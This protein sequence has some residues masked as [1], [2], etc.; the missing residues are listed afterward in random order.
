MGRK[1]R[2]WAGN[3]YLDDKLRFPFQAKCI[4]RRIL[5]HRSGKE[6]P[7]KSIAWRQK[8][9]APFLTCLR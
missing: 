9:S 5:F 6:K 2:P 7:L 8:M 3:S 1:S 4:T